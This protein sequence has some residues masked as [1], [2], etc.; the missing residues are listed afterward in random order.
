MTDRIPDPGSEFEEEGIPDHEGPLPGKVATGDQQ[1]GMAV[2]ADAPE[3]SDDHGVTAEEQREGDRIET[4]VSAEEPDVDPVAE[5][6]APDVVDEQSEPE[7]L[8]EAE[9]E[10]TG[11]PEPDEVS[12]EP[13]PEAADERGGRLVDTDEGVRADAEKDEVGYD[14]GTDRGGFTAEER[15]IHVDPES[16]P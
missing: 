14:V 4:W 1:E 3:Y 11:S 12:A 6:E 10:E 5:R 8:V 9:T 15:S 7:S 16:G 2:P 13:Y